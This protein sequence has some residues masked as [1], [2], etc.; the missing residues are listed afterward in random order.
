MMKKGYYVVRTYADCDD[1]D[2]DHKIDLARRQADHFGPY[3]MQSKRRQTNDRCRRRGYLRLKFPNRRMARAY[4]RRVR[5][6]GETA[7]RTRLMRNP[8]RY[9]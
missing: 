9:R 7:L 4:L 8:N 1:A 3:G 6:L 5:P 2:Y